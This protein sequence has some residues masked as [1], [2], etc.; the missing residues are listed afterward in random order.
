MGKGSAEGD[1]KGVTKRPIGGPNFSRYGPRIVWRGVTS[2][3]G[4]GGKGTSSGE[5]RAKS[6]AA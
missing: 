1:L 2:D 6:P 5:V 4:G 3:W